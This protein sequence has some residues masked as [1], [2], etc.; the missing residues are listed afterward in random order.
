VPKSSLLCN[1]ETSFL[2]RYKPPPSG[3]GNCASPV[4]KLNQHPASARHEGNGAERRAGASGNGQRQGW[5][6]ADRRQAAEVGEVLANQ[7]AGAQQRAVHWKLGGAESIDQ[8]AIVAADGLS[9][10]ALAVC[11]LSV[12]VGISVFEAV[13][14]HASTKRSLNM[15]ANCVFASKH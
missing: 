1:G 6:A 3:R 12:T 9:V 10:E 2:T 4:E 7:N 11:T 8:Q 5:V 13:I 15:T 14:R